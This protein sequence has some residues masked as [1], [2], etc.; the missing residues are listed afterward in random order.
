MLIVNSGL[1][2]CTALAAHSSLFTP[3]KIEYW[4]SHLPVWSVGQLAGWREVGVASHHKT[5]SSST[6]VFFA[7]LEKKCHTRYTLLNVLIMSFLISTLYF[8]L[9][10]GAHI[11]WN[12]S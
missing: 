5:I 2:L 10:D 11:S 12:I 7:L 1:A 9:L 8:I 3:S 4:Y 6:A